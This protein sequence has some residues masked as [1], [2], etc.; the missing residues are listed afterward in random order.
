VNLPGLKEKPKK[1]MIGYMD[2]VL[3]KMENRKGCA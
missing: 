3:G 2:D 1:A